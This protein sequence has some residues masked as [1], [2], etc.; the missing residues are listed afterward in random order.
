MILL[1]LGALAVTGSGFITG[2]S[3]F[4]PSNFNRCLQ[5]TQGYRLEINNCILCT[6]AEVGTTKCQSTVT[7]AQVSSN[8]STGTTQSNV[9]DN[10]PSTKNN[11]NIPII[12][13]TAL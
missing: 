8:G 12:V 3:R 1:I 9:S 7:I 5:C 10:Q 2:C 6:V 13:A 11:S 4:D